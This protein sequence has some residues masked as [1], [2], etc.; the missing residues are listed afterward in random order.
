M[1][2]ITIA[3]VEK[4]LKKHGVG[5]VRNTSNLY[6]TETK[7]VGRLLRT[8]DV[9]KL[10]GKV[11]GKTIHRMVEENKMPPPLIYGYRYKW[12]E[13]VVL[14]WIENGR[15]MVGLKTKTEFGLFK[16]KGRC[17]GCHR[18]TPHKVNDKFM[19]TKCEKE[20]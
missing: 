8:A 20:L 13:N 15:P 19:C 1:A 9:M 7:T 12:D 16:H 18:Y 10:L 2:P 6:L 4:D 11:Q 5:L 14:E 17:C 3:G